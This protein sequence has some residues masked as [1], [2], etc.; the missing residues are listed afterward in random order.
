MES[1]R[2]VDFE[3]AEVISPMIYPPRPRLVVSGPLPT[4]GTTVT[5]VPL[6]YVSRPQYYGIQVVG[7]L[8]DIG[9]HPMPVAQPERYTVDLDLV[10]IIGAEGV[11]VIGAS[12]TERLPVPSAAPEPVP[13]QQGG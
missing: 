11:E 8:E 13:T 3:H 5:L 6:R 4:P 12:H 2:L 10:G 1:G 9:P 7:T